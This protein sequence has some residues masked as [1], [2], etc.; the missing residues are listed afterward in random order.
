MFQWELH[1]SEREEGS[2]RELLSFPVPER[3][4]TKEASKTPGKLRMVFS[5]CSLTAFGSQLVFGSLK[6]PR[7]YL[8]T[9]VLVIPWKEGSVSPFWLLMSCGVPVLM[10]RCKCISDSRVQGEKVVQVPVRYSLTGDSDSVISSQVK[11]RPQLFKTWHK[12]YFQTAICSQ[13]LAFKARGDA[14]LQGVI[15][16]SS[17]TKT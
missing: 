16:Y 17:W 7:W 13:Q 14:F 12:K 11:C 15:P 5:Y 8:D 3:P 4:M 2:R 10:A 6:R 1:S 9:T